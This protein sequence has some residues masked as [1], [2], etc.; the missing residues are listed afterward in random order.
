MNVSIN[1]I[2]ERFY[3]TISAAYQIVGLWRF[4][5]WIVIFQMVTSSGE[6]E[7][8]ELQKLLVYDEI[9]PQIGGQ[10]LRLR[11]HSCSPKIRK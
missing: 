7:L 2:Y 4:C 8:A 5:L 3:R 9:C 11:Q 6:V 10:T 1:I